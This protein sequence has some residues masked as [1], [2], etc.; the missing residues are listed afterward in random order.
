MYEFI[1]PLF[2]EDP[3]YSSTI[4]LWKHSQTNTYYVDDQTQ[5]KPTSQQLSSRAKQ[6]SLMDFTFGKIVYDNSN[7]K[8]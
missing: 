3:R 2:N 5:N 4:C 8:L 6:I 1:R 7:W